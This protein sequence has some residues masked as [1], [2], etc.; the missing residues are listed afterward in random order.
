MADTGAVDTREAI[1][2]AG[3]QAF[4]AVRAAAL[5]A[6]TAAVDTRVA[7]HQADD[8][9]SAVACTAVVEAD[10]KSGPELLKVRPRLACVRRDMQIISMFR[11]CLMYESSCGPALTYWLFVKHRASTAREG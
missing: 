6:G 7:I 2:H 11:S 8:T 3:C 4:V 1:L 10:G 5:M 9:A